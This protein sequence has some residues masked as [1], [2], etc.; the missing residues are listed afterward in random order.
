MK[1]ITSFYFFLKVFEECTMES[2][3]VS[4]FFFFFGLLCLLSLTVPSASS[5]WAFLFCLIFTQVN[6]I[7]APTEISRYRLYHAIVFF[8]LTL[9]LAICPLSS[10][11]EGFTQAGC[12][13]LLSLILVLTETSITYQICLT[14]QLNYYFITSCKVPQGLNSRSLACRG[15]GAVVRNHGFWKCHVFN[16]W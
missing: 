11:D 3:S 16:L 6:P 8:S 12:L 4:N 14:C 9:E 2:C 5:R 7:Q 13:V 15:K 1:L 10:S